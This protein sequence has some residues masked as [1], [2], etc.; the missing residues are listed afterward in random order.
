MRIIMLYLAVGL[1]SFVLG[2]LLVLVYRRFRHK[3]TYVVGN[4]RKSFFEL[5]TSYHPILE[6]EILINNIVTKVLKEDSIEILRIVKYMKNYLIDV[7]TGNIIE[8]DTL[9]DSFKSLLGYQYNSIIDIENTSPIYN[10]FIKEKNELRCNIFPF[11]IPIL[12]VVYFVIIAHNKKKGNIPFWNMLNI[13]RRQLYPIFH[14]KESFRRLK[15]NN[16]LMGNTFFNG[17]VP[18]CTT[19][20][21]G[22]I[23]QVN[24]KFSDLFDKTIL[25]IQQIIT[26][27]SYANIMKG[28]F[29]EKDIAH[30]KL[31]L[32]ARG[33]PIHWED[34]TI[35]G[36]V[37]VIMDESIQYLL[38][39]KLEVSEE[40][41]RKLIKKLPVGLAILSRG[42]DIYFVNDNFLYSLGFNEFG[43]MQEKHLQELFEISDDELFQITLEIENKETLTLKISS[44]KQYGSKVYS[45]NMR[46]VFLGDEDMIELVLQDISLESALYKQLREKTQLLEDELNTAKIMQ[47]HILAIPT[48]Y[49]AGV[50]FKT[51]YKPS[52]KL[53]GDF[54]DIIPIDDNHIAVVI[55]DVSGH[56]VSA[57]LI[58]STLKILVEFAPKD[59]H[60]LYEMINYL[61][62]GLLKI[63][64][65]DHFITLFYGIINTNQYKMDYI[66][67]GHPFPMVYDNRTDEIILLKGVGFPLG[68]FKNLP[69]EDYIETIKLPENCKILF[70]TDGLLGFKK[71][72][73]VINFRDLQGIF[74]QSANFPTQ[75][76]MDNIYF[77]VLKDSVKFAEDDISM[78]LLMIDKGM[79]H[80]NYI[81]IPSNVMEIDLA[82]VKI[83]DQVALKQKLGEEDRWKLYTA[84]YEGMI[85]AVEH[86]NR[87]NVQKRVTIIYRIVDKW[88]ITKI[89]DE[90]LGF[91]VV[92]VPNP[93]DEE[94]ILKPSGRGVYMMYKIMDKVKHNRRGNEVTMFLKAEGK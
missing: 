31:Y 55:A 23:D 1:S 69:F 18:M 64:P 19:R 80:K 52:S 89:R 21:D 67:C 84:L 11:P 41:Y 12:D 54:F 62:I 86:G 17:P 57:S 36:S 75:D 56:G 28:N 58:C 40:R 43:E 16:E 66:N 33:Y 60:R 24:K 14:I 48:V 27:K 76:I 38:Y 87:F 79:T 13:V 6:P 85:N 50:R 53:G 92:D 35:Q 72:D 81:S 22:T 32:K 65:E 88:I 10:Y 63:I 45:V 68:S 46:K 29:I 44:K 4:F 5:L 9:R 34:G 93:L 8:N 47:E 15:E 70:Y 90:G 77:S 51:F 39:K 25:N 73:R 83:I 2:I 7:S 37:F 30:N 74:L 82:I 59:P 26:P 78:L 3:E 94:N 20:V 49:T 91:Q 61:N 71:N 42:G